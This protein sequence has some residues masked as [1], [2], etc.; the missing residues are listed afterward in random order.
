MTALITIMASDRASGIVSF[1]SSEVITLNEP[2][3]LS[4][5]NSRA[6]LGLTRAPGVYGIVNVPY[7]VTSV[8]G[9]ENV[10][11]LTPVTGFVTFRDREVQLCFYY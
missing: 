1:E 4:S 9:G 3:P 7:K 2:T 6:E 5:I 11:D 8:T 10:T